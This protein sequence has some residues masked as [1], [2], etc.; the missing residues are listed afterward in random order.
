MVDLQR[1]LNS[2]TVD[3]A[4]PADAP[5][6][7]PTATVREVL[8]LL[9]ERSTGCA[10]ICD[11]E[12]LIGIFTERD[13]LRLMA[14]ETDWDAPISNVMVTEPVTLSEQSTVA[15][16]VAKMAAGGYRRMPLVGS[17][18][19]AIGLVKVA[20]ILHYLVQHFPSVVYTLPP[21]PHHATQ[22]REG[23]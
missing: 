18:G 17:D 20:G 2:E 1:N 14:E 3:H 7:A 11:D 21:T 22:E 9:R 10:L 15:E 6:A 12:K 5:R 8:H 13:A 23:A 4:D 16:A 19:K